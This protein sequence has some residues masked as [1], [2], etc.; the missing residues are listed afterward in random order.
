MSRSFNSFYGSN[1][2]LANAFLPFGFGDPK[3]RR[4]RVTAAS[5]RRVA[6]AL[7]AILREQNEALSPSDARRAH[8]QAL[9]ELGT[10]VV[11]TG[12][13][14]G[15][16][17]GPLYTVYKA[18]SAVAIARALTAETGVR[19]V[20]LFWLQTEDHDFAEIA[21]CLTPVDGGA[22]LKLE[23]MDDPSLA[24]RSLADRKLG[25]EVTSLVD[26]LARSIEGLPNAAEVIDLLRAHYRPGVTPGRAFAN[27]LAALF[28]G[29]GL[30]VFDPRCASAAR[31]AA[32]VMQTALVEAPRIEALLAE[33]G[34]A[35]V[36]AGF[37][38]QIQLR[39]G[40]PLA[41][42]HL[43]GEQGPRH[44][45]VRRGERFTVPGHAETFNE[46][47]LLAMLERE[48][49]R[50]STSALLRPIVQ[51]TLL[52]T[53]VYVGGAAEVDYFAQL[54]PL[55]PVFGLEAPLVA[56]RAHLR[57]VPPRAR[58]LLQ[59]LGIT[60]T[61]LNQGH[62]ALLQKLAT[63]AVEGAAPGPEWLAEFEQRLN[64]L[65][66]TDPALIRGIERT[67]GSVRHAVSRL[68]RRHQRL[69]LERDKVL[70]DRLM[71]VEGWLRPDGA[72]QERAYAFPAFAARVG[73]AEF[74]R[75]ISAAVDPF[76]PSMRE[77]D[78]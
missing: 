49:L 36:E 61:D 4:A 78:L 77:I 75:A 9:S 18:A 41:F 14:V 57:M 39:P 73:L 67:R 64:G 17:L 55:Y 8:L 51:D 32:P 58:S 63:P 72:P 11:V 66:A 33:R 15:L 16:F 34:R 3:D 70:T 27:V 6:P 20:P 28:A 47:E 59:K 19:C 12:Q 35:L 48:P 45:L 2:M 10:A 74:H 69:R 60:A 21:P 42:F 62:D 31:L 30:I 52:P 65:V 43:E 5:A 46:S 40:S 7:L 24:R 44:R 1:G 53:A 29:D 22:P 38:E 23:L 71:R 54:T 26:E 13:Q 56:E 25:P 50:F 37:A 76:N 68:A